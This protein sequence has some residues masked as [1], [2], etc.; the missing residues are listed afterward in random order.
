MLCISS[1]RHGP[2]LNAIYRWNSIVINRD[3]GKDGSGHEDVS[4][5]R[6]R[7][8]RVYCV[9]D[10]HH[11]HLDS[12]HSGQYDNFT[13]CRTFKCWIQTEGKKNSIRTLLRSVHTILWPVANW[14]KCEMHLLVQLIR[15]R[16]I[17]K[18]V[19]LCFRIMWTGMIIK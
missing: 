8:S 18:H 17:V 3:E 16:H 1:E 7:Y 13:V 12:F 14:T 10:L 11:P 4:T 2:I 5:Q 15:R 19:W 6:T 9:G